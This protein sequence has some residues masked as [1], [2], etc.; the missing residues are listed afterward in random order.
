MYCFGSLGVN[1]Y[2]FVIYQGSVLLQ[3]SKPNINNKA[4]LIPPTPKMFLKINNKII[5]SKL[6]VL[7]PKITSFFDNLTNLIVL[8]ALFTFLTWSSFYN[9]IRSKINLKLHF[10]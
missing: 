9:L 2:T 6:F 4:W 8:H 5:T 3:S 7:N 10:A 1:S